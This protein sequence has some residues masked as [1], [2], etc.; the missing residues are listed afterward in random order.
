MSSNRLILPLK[1]SLAA[2]FAT[3]LLFGLCPSAAA[4]DD[5]GSKRVQTQGDDVY[6]LAPE[7]V[8][9][10]IVRNVTEMSGDYYI[11]TDGTID[12]PV[13]GQVHA[14]GMTIKQLTDFLQRGLAKEL[15]DPEVT[16]NVRQPHPN[17]IYIG[18]AVA[19]GGAFE[20]KKGWRLS[21]L[22]AVAGGLAL[23]PERAN[24]I[25]FRQDS[26]TQKVPLRKIF[27]D[28]DDASDA[29][30]ESGDDV[31]IQVDATVRVNVVGEVKN[32]GI[33]EVYD[34]QGAVEALASSGGET[35]SA[36]LSRAHITR[37]GQDIPVDLYG[38]VIDGDSA[39]NVPVQD[40]DT[41]YIPQQ[42]ARVSVTGTV[43][44]AGPQI[45]PDGRA[46]TLTDAVSDAGGLGARAKTNGIQLLRVGDDGKVH[47]TVYDY[48]KI[49]TP[50][51]PDP[52]L[53]DKDVIFV[54]QSGAANIS[55]VSGLA[56]LYYILRVVTGL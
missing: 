25:I 52:V 47:T 53:K 26:P 56:N 6:V 15:R 21:E 32:T 19:H 39:K 18:G 29:P 1:V 41:L 35:P 50:S 45:L 38:A 9:T 43:P 11:R 55:D 8:L 22:I 5:H 17:R 28:A 2:I 42:Y 27:I 33:H 4:S 44:R 37:K 49:G 30:V 36:A 10:I 40:G 24:A 13:V 51:M 3:C 48:K 20:F 46:W 31:Y 7:E 34:G 23:P 14:S 54:P 16:I 12:F